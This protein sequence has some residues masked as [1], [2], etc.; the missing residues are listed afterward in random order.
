MPSPTFF[1]T[2]AQ[3]SRLGAGARGRRRGVSDD[4]R[5][6][7]SLRE[8]PEEIPPLPWAGRREGSRRERRAGRPAPR[9]AAAATLP[10]W[11]P[12]SLSVPGG[13]GSPGVSRCP[14]PGERASRSEEEGA[15]AARGFRRAGSGRG[16]E[17]GSRGCTGAEGNES[18]RTRLEEGRGEGTGEGCLKG[19]GGIRSLSWPAMFHEA[20][21][22]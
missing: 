4:R 16:G 14:R 5:P 15:E 18:R 12:L 1:V 20:Q 9:R 13:R 7:Y 11:P 3:R 6:N 21:G 8:V 2:Q 19:E 10:L 22:C 17:V